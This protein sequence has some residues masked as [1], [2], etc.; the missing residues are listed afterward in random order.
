MEP[1][2]MFRGNIATP[3]DIYHTA[4]ERTGMV[5]RFSQVMAIFLK[6]P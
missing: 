2:A 6:I 1:G 3:C 4:L 5:K